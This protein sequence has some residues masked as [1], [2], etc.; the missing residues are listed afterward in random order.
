MIK[1]HALMESISSN[2]HD[3]LKQTGKKLSLPEKKF[4]RGNWGYM[5]FP[6]HPTISTERVLTF[7]CSGSTLKHDEQK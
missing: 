1:R 2:L 3:F 7:H 6:E 4:L 5:M